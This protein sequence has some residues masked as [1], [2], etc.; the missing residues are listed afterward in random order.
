MTEETSRPGISWASVAS[1]V[2]GLLTLAGGT[3]LTGLPALLLGLRGLRDVHAAGGRLRGRRLA[4]AGMVLGGAGT[5]LTVCGVFSLLVLRYHA[6]SQRTACQNNL[7]RIGMAA[8]KYYD[9]SDHFPAAAIPNPDLPPTQRLSWLVS[10]LPYLD[11][12]SGRATPWADLAARVNTKQ[13]WDAPANAPAVRTRVPLFRCPTAVARSRSADEAP[14]PFPLTSYIGFAGV[15]ERAASLPRSAPEAGVFGYDRGISRDEA[16][17]GLSA[18]MMASET[19]W[20]PGPWAAGG[21]ATVRG[22]PAE[23]PAIGP[24]RPFGSYHPAGI[25]VLWMDVSVRLIDRDIDPRAF[26]I[27]A[28]LHRDGGS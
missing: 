13:A 27:Q 9:E 16:E 6:F 10:L 21:S 18:T 11:E 2:L 12:G 23:G 15:G 8:A 3:I 5:V 20:E 4:I 7:R 25:N 26:R 19:V 14:P 24:D 28:T 17:A 22:V 1:L